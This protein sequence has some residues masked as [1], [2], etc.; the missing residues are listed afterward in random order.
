LCAAAQFKLGQRKECATV[1]ESQGDTSARRRREHLDPGHEQLQLPFDG[2]NRIL[3]G[4]PH[5]SATVLLQFYAS[6]GR[7]GISFGA[8]V[9]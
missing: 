7:L 6:D 4:R 1:R 5:T 2:G 8:V 3:A 9:R